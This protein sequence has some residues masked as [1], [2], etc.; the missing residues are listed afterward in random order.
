MGTSTFTAT[1]G[2]AGAPGVAGVDAFGV[3]SA[4]T[5]APA[6]PMAPPPTWVTERMEAVRP[7]LQ[8]H[9]KENGERA[10]EA[11]T[12]PTQGWPGKGATILA[13]TLTALFHTPVE[14]NGG[15]ELLA[16]QPAEAH[17]LCCAV[18]EVGQRTSLSVELA[19]DCVAGVDLPAKRTQD[20]PQHPD[21][22]AYKTC[23]STT[24]TPVPSPCWSCC[25]CRTA[26]RCSSGTC[27]HCWS[28]S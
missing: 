11:H 9:R 19:R 24:H 17:A 3:P 25:S 4:P 2:A 15:K 1:G 28:C 8:W 13:F 23:A 6:P 22:A 21:T 12:K 7:E 18:D 26:A 5:A 14:R 20:Q 27:M 10:G 16:L